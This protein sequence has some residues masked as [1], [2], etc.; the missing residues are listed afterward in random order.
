MAKPNRAAAEAM[1][2]EEFGKETLQ[3]DNGLQMSR[4]PA[5]QL[6]GPLS[7]QEARQSLQERAHKQHLETLSSLSAFDLA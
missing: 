7:P 4:S 1:D 2:E 6:P 3:Q 5:S